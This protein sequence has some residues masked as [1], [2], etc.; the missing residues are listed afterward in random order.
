MTFNSRRAQEL[1]I[2]AEQ[3]GC[4]DAFHMAAFHAYFR[5]GKNLAEE[6]ILLDLAEESGLSRRKAAMALAEKYWG[7]R[8]D[9]DWGRSRS[10]GINAAPTFILNHSRLVGAQN[11]RTLQGLMLEHNV[12]LKKT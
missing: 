4:G 6:D 3:Q 1:G 11:Y 2:W 12:P 5:D 9:E 7:K 10:M 8:V